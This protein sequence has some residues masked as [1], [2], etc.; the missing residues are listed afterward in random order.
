MSVFVPRFTESAAVRSAAAEVVG[1]PTLGFNY[2]L[3]AALRAVRFQRFGSLL[4]KG[5]DGAKPH[6]HENSAEMFYI[7]D[8]E[9]K[10]FRDARS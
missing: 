9:S 4:D 8:G 10:C 7:M 1:A 6:H 5:A 3:T 2:W